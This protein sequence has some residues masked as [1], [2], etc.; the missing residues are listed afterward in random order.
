MKFT[1]LSFPKDESSHDSVIEWW[2]F[3]GRLKSE[4]GGE[5][6]F[7]YCLFKA[8]P[9]RVKL[10]F[11]DKLPVKNFYF[12]H[13]LISDI[14]KK[15]FYPNVYLYPEIDKESFNREEVFIK[16]QKDFLFEKIGDNKYSLKTPDLDLVLALKK[17]PLLIDGRGWID[18]GAKDTYY[19]S[20][21]NLE[22]KGKIK[23][24]GKEFSVEGKV[25]MD[26]QWSD[27]GYHP[28]DKW[29]WFSVQLENNTEVL[30]F[31]YGD[32]V[33]TKSAT[34]SFPDGRQFFTRNVLFEPMGKIWQSPETKADYELSW[35]IK[36]PEINLKIKT[37]PCNNDQEI[38]FGNI[39]YWEGG[40][41]IEAEDGDSKIKG[42][43]FMEMVG[44]PMRES[45]AK[46]FM[47]RSRKMVNDKGG[48][49]SFTKEYLKKGKDFVQDR[50][51]KS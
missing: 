43:G 51:F 41:D 36:I 35:L 37:S 9:T 1:P 10:P 6:V 3:N 5:Y 50:Y 39:N 25:W 32:K 46:I 48:I 26:R 2:Y 24:N 44:V 29:T 34:V 8:D 27:G 49:Q 13:S 14:N 47:E 21:S 11:L 45:L 17:E 23:I 42:I 15:T 31:E 22:A 7:M 38:I 30:C 16:A 18:L 28:E 12:S 20:L 4:D 33:K 19:Y 40:L